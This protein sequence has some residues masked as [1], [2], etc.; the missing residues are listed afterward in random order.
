MDY[1][2]AKALKDAGYPGSEYWIEIE[3]EHGGKP[4]GSPLATLEELIEACGDGAFGIE[5]NIGGEWTAHIGNEWDDLQGWKYQA[6]GPAADVATAKLWLAL[7]K[8]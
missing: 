4:D 1:A 7:Q 2:L 6:R 5:R 3:M 8:K